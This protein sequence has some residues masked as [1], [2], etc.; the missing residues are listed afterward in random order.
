MSKLGH[1]VPF[2]AWGNKI[3]YPREGTACC[4]LAYKC[5]GL[6]RRIKATGC[7]TGVTAKVKPCFLKIKKKNNNVV[8]LFCSLSV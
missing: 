3:T 8:H 2:A 7:T 4:R 6:S 1:L 5:T